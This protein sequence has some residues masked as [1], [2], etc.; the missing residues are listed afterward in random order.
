MGVILHRLIWQ[1]FRRLGNCRLRQGRGTS[2]PLWTRCALGAFDAYNR[3]QTKGIH[4]IVYHGTGGALAEIAAFW[5]PEWFSCAGVFAGSPFVASW[6]VRIFVCLSRILFRSNDS[7]GMAV[8]LAA[9][10][11]KRK[12][13]EDLPSALQFS[14]CRRNRGNLSAH[15]FA[16]ASLGAVR[17]CVAGLPTSLG[18]ICIVCVRDRVGSDRAV[19][20]LPEPERTG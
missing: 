4:G 13:E 7:S 18:W 19:R 8:V 6:P 16:P 14:S 15:D 17:I 2:N 1:Q 5:I 3:V 10:C 12:P 11:G 20:Y 9:F